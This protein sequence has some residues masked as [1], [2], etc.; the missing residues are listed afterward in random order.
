VGNGRWPELGK[1]G[2]GVRDLE[3]V[4]RVDTQFVGVNGGAFDLAV[5]KRADLAKDGVCQGVD[6]VGIGALGFA[7]AFTFLTIAFGFAFVFARGRVGGHRGCW[8]GGVR[9]VEPG[10][11]RIGFVVGGSRVGDSPVTEQLTGA[12][13]T[14][15]GVGTGERQPEVEGVG[16]DA[17]GWGS[18]AIG[19][20]VGEVVSRGV[21]GGRKFIGE[22]VVKGGGCYLIVHGAVFRP[23][24]DKFVDGAVDSGS[25]FRSEEADVE[26]S[27][28]LPG[29]GIELFNVGEVRAWG[30]R[31][32][33]CEAQGGR[34]E[35]GGDAIRSGGSCGCSVGG[36]LGG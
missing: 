28:E 23:P 24:E 31:R 11:P 5:G 36:E 3:R 22:N 1:L 35:G 32:E 30:G 13:E 29:E 8:G 10:E 20:G 21:V 18:K 4:V 25:E 34:R 19:V 9:A 2:V 17:G 7:S 15:A 14:G 16:R 27:G 6:G 12:V 26:I 33:A